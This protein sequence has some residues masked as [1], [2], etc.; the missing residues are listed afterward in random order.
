MSDRAPGRV[1]DF[2]A[3]A[4]PEKVAARAVAALSAEYHVTPVAEPTIRGLLGFMDENG[5]EVS[6]VVPV[7]TRADQVRSINDWAAAVNGE[8]IVCFGAVHPDLEDLGAEVERMVG[9]GLKGLKIQ[10]NFQQCSP[11]DP[12]LFPAYE[13]AEG[14]LI[15]LFHSGQEIVRVD[16]VYARPGALARVK[17]RF[18][19]LT[20][21]AAHLGGYQMWSEVREHLVGRDLFFETSYCPPDQLSDAETVALIR[22]HGAHRILFGSDF[23][24]GRAGLDLQ[25]LLGLG[26]GEQEVEAICRGNARALLGLGGR[27]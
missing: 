6:V 8:R 11:D 16:R 23:P 1:V 10:P 13:A 27:T 4:F 5:V 20:M 21:V 22:A 17:D 25:R 15:A 24:W 3:H 2:H 7:A 18:P 14:R 9:L 26:L 12:R 19:H